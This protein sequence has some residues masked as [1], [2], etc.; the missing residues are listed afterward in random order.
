[1]AIKIYRPTSPGRRGMSVSAFD[2]IT[3][4]EPE[5][6]LLAPLRKKGGRNSRGVVTVRHRGGGHKRRY[7]IIDF[8]R[9]N[10]GI[11]GRVESIEYDP[12]R[13]ARIALVVFQNGERRYILAPVGLNVGD[14]VMSGPDADIRPG[15]ALPIRLIPLGT[16][17]HNIELYP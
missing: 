14:T 12:N 3:R 4:K 9:D 7:R 5:R 16:T 1:M 6:S 11:P 2:D 10:F 17:I 13:S 15:N 8:R